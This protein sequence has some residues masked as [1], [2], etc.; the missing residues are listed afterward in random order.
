[1]N[2]VIGLAGKIGSGK[3]TLG[4]VLAKT[5]GAAQAS[6]GNYVRQIA[7]QQNL[8]ETREHL[9][10]IGEELVENDP[11]AFCRAVIAQAQR[12]PGQ[13]LVIEG[14]RHGKVVRI[15][16]E[17]VAPTLFCLIFV[18]LEEPLRVAR[19]AQRQRE[20]IETLPLLEAHST[21]REVA[22]ELA[23]QA[24][25]IVDGALPVEENTKRIRAFLDA[26]QLTS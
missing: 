7:R 6:F 9:Q 17:M 1:M 19:I 13:S 4:P 14:F 2:V 10:Q 24:D 18:A 15:I 20:Q 25:L 8:A 16:R 11:A 26:I 12:Q 5:L 23:T 21:E 3:T 22:L